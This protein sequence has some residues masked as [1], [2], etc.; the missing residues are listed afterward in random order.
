MVDSD[1]VL[2]PG[3]GGV[4]RAVFE[5]LRAQDVPVRFM[6]RHE[7]ERAAEVKELGAEVVSGDLSRPEAV[8]AA[9]PG[10]IVP[11]GSA[12]TRRTAR[13]DDGPTAPGQPLQPNGQR[14]RARDGRPAAINRGVR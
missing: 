6:V 4:G 11:D 7:D 1:L 5:H 9:L 10:R 3:A 14:R 12:A 2:N 8:A 13:R